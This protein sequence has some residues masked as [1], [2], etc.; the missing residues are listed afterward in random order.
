MAVGLESLTIMVQQSHDLDE[1]N[2]DEGKVGK[3]NYSDL[4]GIEVYQKV[5]SLK[6]VGVVL[7]VGVVVGGLVLYSETEDLRNGFLSSSSKS[8]GPILSHKQR[9]LP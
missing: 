1:E 9:M 4:K 6:V 3:Y 8:E 5:D 7:L 2:D